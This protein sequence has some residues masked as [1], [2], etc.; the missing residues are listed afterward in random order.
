[1]AEILSW[2]AALGM[3]TIVITATILGPFLKEPPQD[4]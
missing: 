2:I 4:D 1:M 3:L